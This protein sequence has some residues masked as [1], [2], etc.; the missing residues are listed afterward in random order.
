MIFT[1]NMK[2][3]FV[4]SFIDAGPPQFNCEKKKKQ[5]NEK[6]E[7]KQ[8]KAKQNQTIRILTIH[9]AANEYSE[10]ILCRSTNQWIIM[11]QRSVWKLYGIGKCGICLI[12]RLF[13]EFDIKYL[14]KLSIPTVELRDFGWNSSWNCRFSNQIF[15]MKYLPIQFLPKNLKSTLHL[16]LSD[17]RASRIGYVLFIRRWAFACSLLNKT[18]IALFVLKMDF[19][20]NLTY[21][22]MYEQNAVKWR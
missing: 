1:T 6:R 16:S 13:L 12:F 5:L 20:W 19:V 3:D 18:S 9:N 7:K 15:P 8:N 10:L 21:W 17:F 14:M 11:G 2:C 22:S 4:C